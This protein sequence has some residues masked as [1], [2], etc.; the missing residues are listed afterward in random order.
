MSSSIRRPLRVGIIGTG[1]GA[2]VVAGAFQAGH[3]EVTGV[4]TPRDR[5]AVRALCQSDVDLISVHSPP[6]LHVEHV[7]MA[8]ESGR[9]VMCDKPFGRSVG[10]AVTMAQA[11]DAAGVVNLLNFEF[12][13]QP[14]RRTMHD[15][16][17]SGAIGPPE[18]LSYTAFTSGSRVPL[19]PWGW[20]FDRSLGG[21]W[22]GA[23]G[24]HAIDLVRWLLGDVR[25]AGAATWITVNERPDND[26]RPQP[27]TAEDA[28][29][30]WLELASGATATVDTSF[31]SGVP[32]APRILITGPDGAIENVG[33]ARLVVRRRDRDRQEIG[34]PS[35]TGDSHHAAMTAW[36]AEVRDAVMEGRQI[37]PSFADG[38][39]CMRV[40]DQW[41][42]VPPTHVGP[43]TGVSVVSAE[44]GTP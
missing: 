9:A 7:T 8:V 30:G 20:L 38:L 1:F 11:A 19:R 12:R 24:S 43:E 22:V 27:C 28:F 29:V 17:I 32:L 15:L 2:R 44:A 18:H 4:V 3:C 34:F 35:G 25:R 37:A 42:A 31:T 36:A 13:H 5:D 14:A 40:M 39:A 6:F 16:V 41:R 23:F 26:G 33:D 10:E 21:G